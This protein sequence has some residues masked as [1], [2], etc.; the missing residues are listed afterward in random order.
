MIIARQFK[1][2]ASAEQRRQKQSRDARRQMRGEEVREYLVAL[3]HVRRQAFARDLEVRPQQRSDQ[4]EQ[5]PHRKTQ[6]SAQ[7]NAAQRGAIALGGEIALHH[8]LVGGVLL[9]VVRRAVQQQ[10]EQRR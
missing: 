3:G 9:Q 5:R 6:R 10:H 8:R 2:D 1:S 4:H 7:Q